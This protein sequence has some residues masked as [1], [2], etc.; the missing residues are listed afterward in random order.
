MRLKMKKPTRNDIRQAALDITRY[1]VV[2]MRVPDDAKVR[3]HT[4]NGSCGP[5]EG[6]A[7]TCEVF[8]PAEHFEQEVG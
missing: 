8:V 2:I 5:V 1:F 7:V 4:H 6:W 3:K